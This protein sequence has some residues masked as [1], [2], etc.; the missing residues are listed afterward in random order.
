MAEK[1]EPLPVVT[2]LEEAPLIF[3]NGVL[4]FGAMG[5][6]AHFV[7][8]TRRDLMRLDGTTESRLMVTADLRIPVAD[9]GNF[10]DAFDKVAL[11]AA[12]PQGQA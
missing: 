1:S 8:V 12:K 6:V 2:G 10:R 7:L 3:A 11:G 5:G 9:I 4:N